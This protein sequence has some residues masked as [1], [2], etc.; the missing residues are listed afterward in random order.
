MT[1]AKEGSVG[2]AENQLKLHR[3]NT[4]EAEA[5]R[6]T[7]GETIAANVK[8]VRRTMTISRGQLLSKLV[9]CAQEA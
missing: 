6:D 3:T 1:T 8:Q 5:V 2:I 4:C 9:S 7:S